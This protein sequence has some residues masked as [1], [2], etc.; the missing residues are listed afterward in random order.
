[1]APNI[2]KS[3][4]AVKSKAD[5][6]KGDGMSLQ[7]KINPKNSIPKISIPITSPGPRKRDV[8]DLTEEASKKHKLDGAPFAPHSISL[9]HLGH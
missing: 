5:Q 3:F 9:S 1:M 6:I 4:G 8:V 7:K 2:P